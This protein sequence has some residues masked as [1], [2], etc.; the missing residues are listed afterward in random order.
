MVWCF[1]HRLIEYY[2]ILLVVTVEQM[3]VVLQFGDLNAVS[4][5]NLDKGKN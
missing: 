1:Y 4:P 2:F 3:T 5:G